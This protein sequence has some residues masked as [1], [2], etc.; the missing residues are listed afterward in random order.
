MKK[1]DFNFGSGYRGQLSMVNTKGELFLDAQACK[2]AVHDALTYQIYNGYAN[3]SDQMANHTRHGEAILT[4]PIFVLWTSPKT[5]ERNAAKFMQL[6]NKIE[7]ILE[8]PTKTVA[9]AVSSGVVD[10]K[11]SPFVAEAPS[12]WLTSPISVS[13]YLTIMR[14]AVFV[15]INEG[16]DEFIARVI[17]RAKSE[18]G[19]FA[20][21]RDCKYL[22]I[23]IRK[24]NWEG[25]LNKSLKCLNREDF[26][27]WLFS[28]NTRGFAIY[29][30]TSDKGPM[31]EREILDLQADNYG[32]EVRD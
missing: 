1:V 23:A 2:D 32:E 6:M 17:E 14:L 24:K 28:T 21:R 5:V 18:K 22:Q 15:R 19:N 13:A 10:E 16:V 31:T 11:A 8:L 27:D 3:V 26:S 20:I 7:S 12:W 4:N 25:L 9:Y 30:S 29:D